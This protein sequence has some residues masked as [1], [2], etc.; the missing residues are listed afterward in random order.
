M[1]RRRQ[2]R[3]LSI[4]QR[5]DISTQEEIVDALREEGIE[6]TQATVSRDIKE[7]GLVKIPT[8]SGTYHYA[9]SSTVQRH[10]IS[11]QLLH[12]LYNSVLRVQHSDCMLVIDTL[13]ATAQAVAEA[14]DA[15]NWEPIIGTLAGER[16]VFAVVSPGDTAP[17]IAR[18]LNTLCDQSS[19][20]EG[21]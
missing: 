14:I 8:D 10:D 1:K 17:E 20:R 15:L 7:L 2:M 9:E 3:I 21:S 11:Q 16:T 5:K 4:L 18:E 6:A 12:T 13:P 19:S